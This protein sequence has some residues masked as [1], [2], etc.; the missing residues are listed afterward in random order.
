MLTYS[1]SF[2]TAIF[3]LHIIKKLNCLPIFC[4]FT[5]PKFIHNMKKII[6]ILIIFTIIFSCN[7][8]NSD[9]NLIIK[10]QVKGLQLGNLLIKQMI[11]DSLVSIDSIRVDGN[12]N[13]EFHTHIN[14]A[15]MMLLELPEVKDGKL[16]FFAEPNDTVKIFTYVESF[17]INPIIKGG[18]NQTKLNEYN[19]MIK[20]FNNKDLD[21][22]QQQFEARKEHFIE[23]ADSIAEKLKSMKKKRK[24]YTLN[25]IFQNKNKSVAPY[26]AMMEF[27]NNPKVLDTIYKVLPEN[28]K[29]SL[30]GKEIKKLIDSSEK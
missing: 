15:Q 11:Q 20:K 30:Y 6:G 10:G 27:Y 21:L 9:K 3:L 23:E 25:F 22:F 14:E 19:Q 26:I 28:I 1:C 2:G 13:F 4:T 24:L 7:K 17:G 16:L 18:M 8:N 29:A 12:E 5:I